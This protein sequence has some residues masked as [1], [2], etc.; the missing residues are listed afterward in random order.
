MAGAGARAA[1]GALQAWPGERGS[2]VTGWTPGDSF[3]PLSPPCPAPPSACPLPS[4]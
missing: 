3:V 1:E 4:S 2:E